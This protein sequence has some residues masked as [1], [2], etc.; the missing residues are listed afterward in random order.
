V[1][2]AAGAR[3]IRSS[4]AGSS[5]CS[6]AGHRQSSRKRP[7][8]TSLKTTTADVPGSTLIEDYEPDDRGWGV[9]TGPFIRPKPATAPDE[10]KSD[11][12]EGES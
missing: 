4:I 12:E 8:N 5:A 6:G 9:V 2:L 1:I 11:S 7:K 3:T 10:D